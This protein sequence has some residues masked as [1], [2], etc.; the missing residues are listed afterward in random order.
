[1]LDQCVDRKL[2]GDEAA[3]IRHFINIGLEHLVDQHRLID[4]PALP[5]IGEVESE[6][7]MGKAV[8]SKKGQVVAFGRAARELGADE[9]DAACDALG[10]IARHKVLRQGKL[11]NF[12]EDIGEK[13]NSKS[14]SGE[15]RPDY[16][17]F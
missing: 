11:D 5:I 13:I 6:L 17:V 10:K 7:K 2:C 14:L 1:L 9:S 3:T 16:R 12:A 4:I 15:F 8:T